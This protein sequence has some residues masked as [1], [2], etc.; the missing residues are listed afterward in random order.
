MC[1]LR[2]K[3]LVDK[4]GSS[5]LEMIIAFI[6]FTGFVFFLF[7]VLKPTDA[8]T[9]SGSVITGLRVSFEDEVYTN[10]SNVFLKVK[11]GVYY[12]N[13]NCFYIGTPEEIFSYK[14]IEDKSRITEL[15]GNRVNSDL[16]KLGSNWRL[17]IFHEDQTAFRIAISPE[18]IDGEI[19][20]GSCAELDSDDYELGDVVER[21]VVSYQALADMKTEYESDYDVLRTSLGVPPIFDFAIV[22]ETLL[23][24]VKMER[25]IPSGVD[26]MAEDYVFG[27]IESDGTFTNERFS[28]KIW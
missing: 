24:E 11:E 27:V 18:F 9:L 19:S 12:P 22:P 17:G 7:T 13:K 6:F 25:E 23:E 3:G 4:R 16:K 26:V 28:F 15:G 21:Q 14:I 5:H 10:L 2:M 1:F 20:V 8:S